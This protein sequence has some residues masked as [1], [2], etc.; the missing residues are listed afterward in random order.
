[1][2]KLDR[3]PGTHKLL[4]PFRFADLRKSYLALNILHLQRVLHYVFLYEFD[5]DDPLP[6]VLD[7]LTSPTSIDTLTS[8]EQRTRIRRSQLL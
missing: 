2:T 1:M 7:R 5:P 3:F 6:S 4:R 8:V